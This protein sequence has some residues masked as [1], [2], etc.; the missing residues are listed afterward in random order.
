MV[1]FL[2][3]N[4]LVG[5][6]TFERTDPGAWRV[7]AATACALPTPP[8]TPHLDTV[9]EAT[10]WFRERFPWV[11]SVTQAPRPV[12]GHLFFEV[13]AAERDQRQQLREAIDS[14]GLDNIVP[15]PGVD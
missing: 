4:E 3:L 14:Y 15:V 5:Q 13:T 2:Q 6:V 12:N 9:A 8:P 11:I 1:S 7:S 10:T